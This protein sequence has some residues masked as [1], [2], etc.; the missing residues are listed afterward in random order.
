M[1]THMNTQAK[2]DRKVGSR[3]RA[4]QRR[5]LRSLAVTAAAC[6]PLLAGGQGVTGRVAGCADYRPLAGVSVRVDGTNVGAVT[7]SDGRYSLPE[8]EAGS[9]KLVFSFTGM[10]S[11]AKAVNLTA[12]KTRT[13]N[14]CMEEDMVA[15]SEVTV[16]ARRERKELTEARQQG[17]PVSMIDGKM[18]A[19]RGTSIAEVINHQ[20]GVKLR[21]VGAVGSETKVNV[22]GLEGNRVQIYMDGKPLN[23]PDGSFNI[24]DIPLQYIDRIEIYKGIVPPE[25]GGDGLGSAINVVTI[26][27]EEAFYDISYSIGSYGA[28]E[29][30][31]LYKHYFPKSKMMMTTMYGFGYA[32]ND[33]TMESPYVEGLTIKRDHD[34]FRKHLGAVTFDFRNTY[35]DECEVEIPFFYSD[36]QLQGIRT[37]IQHAETS[38]WMTVFTPKL[39]KEH[40]LTDRLDMRF[41]GFAGYSVAHLNDTSSYLYNFDGTRLPNSYRGELGSI[42]NLSNDKLQDY[43][44]TLN[45][46]YRLSEHTRVNLNND[47]RFVTTEFNDP[48]ADR[49]K[50]TNFSGYSANVTG[51]IT[52][53]NI[54]QRLWNRL[55]TL[56]TAR[57]YFYG[58]KGQTVDLTY[59]MSTDVIHANERKS[60]WGYSLA[61][62]YD[63][64]PS[65]LLKLAMEHNY[66]LPRS[67]ELLGDR[68]KIVS[69]TRLRP[70]QA[71]NF[72]LGV[73]FDR[74][75]NNF[76]RLQFE[77]N[78]Y[79]MNVTD[80]MML[81]SSN[82]F[83]SNYNLGKAQLYGADAE[84]KWDVNREWFVMLNAT[85][86]KSIDR[87]RYMPGSNT[88]SVTYG[89]QMPHIPIFFVNWS[90]DY[91]RDN[92]F[93]GRG[94]YSRFYYEGG[95]T[96]KYYYGYS[97]TPTQSYAIP[98]SVVHTVG[99]EYA[100]LNR[101]VL[102]SLECHNIFDTKELTNLNYPLAGRT[103]Q[104]KVRITTLKW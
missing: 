22:R 72:N 51:V 95:Y 33:Y 80:M 39:T 65:W 99:T 16:E 73:M 35:F 77:S 17:V 88:P 10:K 53:L 55:T 79:L 14:L 98:K 47:F 104:A 71:D 84:L 85:Y 23:T 59:G 91:R 62:K 1:N 68:V 101:R 37:D 3:A 96:D 38:G 25:F 61:A 29:G 83:L 54:E 87:M 81:R 31:V 4:A 58:V 78:V 36:R 43:R 97:L 11:E 57:N 86:Q 93:G 32:E 21:R 44:Y 26:D 48:E 49:Y 69:N 6:L 56:L 92:L 2:T 30:G 15:L 102:F 90:A 103:V 70:E 28:H 46:K 40:F 76:S 18:L 52:S 94:Q 13:V 74:Y 75:Y 67:E 27:A 50:Q 45:L 5:A 42:P 82:G 60:V 7:G 64:A 63:F 34:R 19:G 8:L 9:Y 41:Y 100:I 89:L 12:G 66:R 20:T 24:N